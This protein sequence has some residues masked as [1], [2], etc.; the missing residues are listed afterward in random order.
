MHSSD[1]LLAKEA[2]FSR[3]EKRLFGKHLSENTAT[4][5]DRT[6]IFLVAFQGLHVLAF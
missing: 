6:L 4:S 3:R 1:A 5:E 2:L